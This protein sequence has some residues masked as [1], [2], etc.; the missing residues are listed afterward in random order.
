MSLYITPQ[1]QIVQNQPVVELNQNSSILLTD[2]IGRQ[3]IVTLAQQ[4][5]RQIISQ[6]SYIIPS[7]LN[8]LPTL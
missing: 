4:P 2:D 7:Y 5:V 8:T 1:G 6:P 3:T